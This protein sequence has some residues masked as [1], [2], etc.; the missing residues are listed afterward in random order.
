MLDAQA[1]FNKEI[2]QIAFKLVIGGRA[3]NPVSSEE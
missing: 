1:E 3:T 2:M